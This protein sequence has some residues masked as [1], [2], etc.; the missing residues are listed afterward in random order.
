MSGEVRTQRDLTGRGRTDPYRLLIGATDGGG[1][2]GDASLSLYIGDVSANDGVPRF[3]R[4]A[5]G[6]TLSVSE[7]S[8][9]RTKFLDIVCDFMY[10]VCLCL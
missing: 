10:Y 7:V 8:V 1:H 6:E 4:P 2:T 5:Q 9:I 3:I